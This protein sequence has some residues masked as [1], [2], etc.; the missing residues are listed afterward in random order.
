M[1]VLKRIFNVI[2]YV[3][4]VI[5]LSVISPLLVSGFLFWNIKRIKVINDKLIEFNSLLNISK[6]FSDKSYYK[7]WK[8]NLEL[9][10]SLRNE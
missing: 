3:L 6:N 10:N 1:K 5:L 9:K 7:A 4:G 2:V 8:D